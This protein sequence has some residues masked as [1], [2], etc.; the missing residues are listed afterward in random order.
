MSHRDRTSYNWLYCI[1]YLIENVLLLHLILMQPLS[2]RART[3][4]YYWIWCKCYHTEI[5]PPFIIDADTKDHTVF[6]QTMSQM[7]L[8]SQS[9]YFF[10]K[11]LWCKHIT[12][13]VL[14][15]SLMQLISWRDRTCFYHRQWCNNLSIVN[16]LNVTISVRYRFGTSF[17]YWLG[18]NFLLKETV[19]PLTLMQLLSHRDLPLTIYSDTA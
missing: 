18:R 4:F 17:Y 19:E 1:R 13:I 5:I 8:L 2:Q 11:C 15:L 3:S 10:Y 16:F 6:F 14:L 7:K 9:L 12:D